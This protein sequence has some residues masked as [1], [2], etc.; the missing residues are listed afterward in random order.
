MTTQQEMNNLALRLRTMPPEVSDALL[1]IL[2]FVERQYVKGYWLP[3]D[4]VGLAVNT[5]WHWLGFSN[6]NARN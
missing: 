4:P 6:T 1:E 2:E 5:I 3:G